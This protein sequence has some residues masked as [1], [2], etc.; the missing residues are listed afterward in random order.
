MSP[1]STEPRPDEPPRDFRS[2]LARETAPVPPRP[3][4]ARSPSAAPPAGPEPTEASAISPARQPAEG[5][6]AQVGAETGAEAAPAAA[7]GAQPLS[8]AQLGLEGANTFV[9]P[10][11]PRL[12]PNQRAERRLNRSL[13]QGLVNADAAVGYGPGGPVLRA[14]EQLVYAST[15]P[16][17]GKALLTVTIDS[18]GK[19]LDVSVGEVSEARAQWER[20][21]AHTSAALATRR[22]SV[23]KGSGMTLQIEVT[24][25][26]ELPSG[27]D[28]GLEI[29]ALGLPIK[30]GRGKRSSRID[31]L[32]SPERL[33]ALDGDPADIGAHARRMVH[34]R[35]ISQ[36]LL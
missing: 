27:R 10:D 24:S 28:P 35:V 32:G 19:L 16:L 26:L 21:A 15:L 31:L 5:A 25:H 18:N 2:E 12:S 34:A 8:L 14:L 11:R 7:D 33:L 6:G 20:V 36:E 9:V 3:G 30:R 4:I 22:L 23:P 1:S 29:R 13:R 17:N